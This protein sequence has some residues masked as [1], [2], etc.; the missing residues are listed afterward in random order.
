MCE[1]RRPPVS[2]L[3]AS[4][5][6]LPHFCAL[7]FNGVIAATLTLVYGLSSEAQCSLPHRC[8]ILLSCIWCH[9]GN[10]R[11][12]WHSREEQLSV[13]QCFRYLRVPKAGL[14]SWI[15]Q[16]LLVLW[17]HK[18]AD[19]GVNIIWNVNKKRECEFICGAQ[20]YISGFLQKCYE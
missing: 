13:A 15:G 20:T 19:G 7:N 6:S 5:A 2:I 14:V 4:L 10:T 18:A 9:H 1:Q 12:G 17:P 3:V 11:A 8:L 16:T